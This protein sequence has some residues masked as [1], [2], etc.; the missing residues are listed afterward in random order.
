MVII[1]GDWPISADGVYNCGGNNAKADGLSNDGNNL[2]TGGQ[3][4][5][6]GS[7]RDMEMLTQE[8]WVGMKRD[9]EWRVIYSIIAPCHKGHEQGGEGDGADD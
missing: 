7:R 2:S 6:T 9:H 8:L 5:S 1:H 4:A 3:I